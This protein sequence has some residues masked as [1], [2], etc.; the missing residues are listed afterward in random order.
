MEVVYSGL[1]LPV[2]GDAGKYCVDVFIEWVMGLVLP[3]DSMPFTVSLKHK[4]TGVRRDIEIIESNLLLQT[5]HRICCPPLDS[6]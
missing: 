3:K 6:L 2:T 5:P 1:I 4:I